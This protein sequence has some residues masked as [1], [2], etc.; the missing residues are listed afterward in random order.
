MKRIIALALAVFVAGEGRAQGLEDR[1]ASASG[2]VAFE[3]ETHGNVCG[4]GSTLFIADS[5]P[6]GWN[7]RSRRTGMHFQYD[8]DDRDG[9]CEIAPA[10]A[11]I[12]H[13]GR[14][15]TSV[16]IR[17]GG[18]PRRADTEL[19]RVSAEDAARFLLAVA[20]R[21][22]GRSAEDAITGANIADVPRVW[23]RLLEIARDD[24]ASESSQK[25]AVFWVS[26]EATTVAVAGLAGVVEDDDASTSL[27]S[28]ALFYLAQRKDG[29]G[30]EPLIRVVRRSKNA[31]IRRDALWFLGQS[32]DPR[33]IR[34]F[35]EILSGR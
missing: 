23:P 34:L 29:E 22:D 27:K 20:P 7:E 18:P 9:P 26:R 24:D 3:F 30:I 10:R 17:V 28:D 4:N 25:A 5:T 16:R 8:R 31:K 35:E 33:A 1:V 2:S 12:E 19:G 32:R 13:Q 14:R 21:L 11:I 15:V 6:P